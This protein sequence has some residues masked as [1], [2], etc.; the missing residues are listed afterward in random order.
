MELLGALRLRSAAPARGAAHDWGLA[1]A[2]LLDPSP[3]LARANPGPRPIPGGFEQSFK[4][5][6]KHPFVHVL[7]PGM[8]SEMST[9]TDFKGVVA[10]SEIRGKAHGSDGTTYDFDTAMRFVQALMSDST[11][12]C[13][14]ARLASSE[15]T[16]STRPRRR[17]GPSAARLGAWYS[18]LRA[19]LD[20][21]N[22][23]LGN[24][25]RHRYRA[26]TLPH[27]QRPRERL[28]RH[29]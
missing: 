28:P 8:G 13:A 11:G 16:S 22:S 24:P 14:K 26:G 21:P 17:S 23:V 1:G 15:L 27:A 25:R 19:V 3:V 5:V 6:S 4:P 18:S 9:I 20:D 29:H 10:G 7:P 2:S 12:G